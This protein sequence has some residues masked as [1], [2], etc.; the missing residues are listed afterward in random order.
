MKIT[1]LYRFPSEHIDGIKCILKGEY[2]ALKNDILRGTQQMYLIDECLIAFWVRDI[3]LEITLLIG[4]NS[5]QAI[6]YVI[7][8]AK[9]SGIQII[10][11]WSEKKGV[12]RIMK[13][14]G[15]VHTATYDEFTIF[16]EGANNA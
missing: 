1:R 4:R 13:K 11:S 14:Y 5:D 3:S 9:N 8:R 15:A 16:L 12:K 6:R 7:E 10:N 2:Q